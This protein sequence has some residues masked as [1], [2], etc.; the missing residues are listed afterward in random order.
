MASHLRPEVSVLGGVTMATLVYGI[1]QT[2]L[3]NISDVRVAPAHDA[4]LAS[5][6]KAAAWTTAALVSGVAL[7]AKDPTIF[8]F[9]ASMIMIMSWWHRH[10]NAV[11][12]E[13]GKVIPHPATMSAASP[14]EA[15]S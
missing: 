11:A 8:V 6:E 7:V 12:P 15:V 2:A 10:A 9:G 3:P 4:D 5:T 1:Y 14:M 13:M